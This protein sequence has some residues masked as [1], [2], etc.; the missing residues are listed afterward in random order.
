MDSVKVYEETEP[1]VWSEVTVW[2]KASTETSGGPQDWERQAKAIIEMKLPDQKH[3]K[4]QY[5]YVPDSE[6]DVDLNI[7]NTATLN[8]VFEL[9]GACT[10]AVTTNNL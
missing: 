8:G 10:S 1:G 4:V 3:L 5:S 7:K 6:L 9:I 2:W